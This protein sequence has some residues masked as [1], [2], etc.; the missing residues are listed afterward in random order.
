MP[1]WLQQRFNLWNQELLLPNRTSIRYRQLTVPSCGRCNS[2]VYG[3]LEQRIEHGSASDSDLW[4]WANKI[5]Y[6]LCRKD[7]LLA[8]DR[9]HPDRKIAELVRSVDPLQRDRLF[10]Y[11]A[12]GAI[13]TEPDPFGSVF[14]FKFQTPQ[15]F[16]FA[17]FLSSKSLCVSL[18]SMGVVCFVTDGQALKRDTAT[19]QEWERL[20]RSLN[21]NDMT[22]FYA[23]LVEHF[24]RHNLHQTILITHGLVLRVGQTIPRDVQPPRKERFRAICRHLGLDWIDAD[25]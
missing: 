17:H 13:K 12:S 5:H 20:P 1:R 22:F 10:L 4:K 24:T 11:C 2:D 14:R 7:E 21:A 16:R 15:P 6:G 9:R 18:G 25:A 23:K 3:P 19:A 8:W